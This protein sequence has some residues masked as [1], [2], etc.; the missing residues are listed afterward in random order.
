MKITK[1]DVMKLFGKYYYHI[2]NDTKI[3]YDL[4]RVPGLLVI[5]IQRNVFNT[6]NNSKNIFLSLLL[7]NVLSIK[8]IILKIVLVVLNVNLKNFL[9]RNFI[10]LLNQLH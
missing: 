7:E 3:S 10:W 4:L 2:D 5:V 6:M 8:R 9:H 1:N